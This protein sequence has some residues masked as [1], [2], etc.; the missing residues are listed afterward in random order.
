MK[1][2][3]TKYGVSIP[4]VSLKMVRETSSEYTSQIYYQKD[5][6][7]IVR[8][9]LSESAFEKMVVIGLDNQNKPTILYV[10]TGSV[11]QC[12]IYPAVI[13]KVLLL[14]N[15]ISCIMAHNHPGN[16]PNPSEADWAITERIRNGGKLLDIT[17]VDH[18]ITDSTCTTSL[19]LRSLSRWGL[20]S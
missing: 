11:E 14:A 10:F 8:P 15:S 17:L 1:P 4:V 6:L 3:F 18:I 7:E 2:R 12:P 13:F 9:F 20:S 5:V 16:T 19:S